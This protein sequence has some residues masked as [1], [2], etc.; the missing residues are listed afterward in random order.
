MNLSARDDWR[1]RVARRCKAICRNPTRTSPMA[2]E[3][4]RTGFRF[5]DRDVSECNL[6]ECEGAA[7]RTSVASVC[8]SKALN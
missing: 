2:D 7:S 3:C 5:T 8:R 4:D 6:V 1:D